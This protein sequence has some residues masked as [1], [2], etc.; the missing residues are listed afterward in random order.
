MIGKMVVKMYKSIK[1][2]LR[3]NATQKKIFEQS[4]GY[5]RYIYN[6]ALDTWKQMWEDYQKDKSLKKPTHRRVRDYLKTIPEPW[7]S[8][9][10]KQVMESSVEDLGKSFNMMWK[11]YG[12][13]PRY[14]SRKN[15]KF[16]ARFYR[17]NDYSLQVKGKKNNKLKLQGIDTLIHMKE[18]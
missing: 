1:I 15:E 9:Q 6:K 2:E 7:E 5:S 18:S 12:R 17:K 14:K 3:P 10:C 16:T 13:Y 11:G 8:S 4:F